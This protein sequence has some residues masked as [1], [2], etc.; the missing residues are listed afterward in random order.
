MPLEPASRSTL[1]QYIADAE[2]FHRI[3]NLLTVFTG[4]NY[5]CTARVFNGPDG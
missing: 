4:E 3:I 5:V 2:E 1:I